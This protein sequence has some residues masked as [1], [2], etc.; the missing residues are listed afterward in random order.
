MVIKFSS[1]T[2]CLALEEIIKEPREL[3]AKDL[4][5]L[6]K[7]ADEARE[8]SKRGERRRLIDRKSTRLNS[9]HSS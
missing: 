5:P 2:T 3:I 4:D 6:L 9:S 1:L 8:S 7:E